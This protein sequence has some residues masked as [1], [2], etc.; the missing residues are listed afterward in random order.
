M[1]PDRHTTVTRLIELSR[2]NREVLAE[3]EKLRRLI[4][5]MF[6]YFER[7]GDVTSRLFVD[8]IMAFLVKAGQQLALAELRERPGGNCS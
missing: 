3:L 1:T 2:E 8:S 4:T 6:T 5:V 7:F